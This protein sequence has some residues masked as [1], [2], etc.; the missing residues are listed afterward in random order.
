MFDPQITGVNNSVL[1]YHP[2]RPVSLRT[3]PFKKRIEEEMLMEE[4]ALTQI[5]QRSHK[6][7]DT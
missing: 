4:I 7:S 2:S 5:R 3:T 1:K 6:T